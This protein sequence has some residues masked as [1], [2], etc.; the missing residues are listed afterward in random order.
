MSGHAGSN[1]HTVNIVEHNPQWPLSFLWVFYIPLLVFPFG[2]V[3]ITIIIIIAYLRVSLDF[4]S[5]IVRPL[6]LSYGTP[7]CT[8]KHIFLLFFTI[9][10]HSSFSQLQL[11]YINQV[12]WLI[13][14][15]CL[16]VGLIKKLW[17]D[18]CQM[19]SWVLWR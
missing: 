2:P 15:L 3:I 11:N 8:H 9:C 7:Q 19:N 5:P 17:L 16:F 10:I 12:M 1:K 14:L 18:L 13:Q 4:I 6:W